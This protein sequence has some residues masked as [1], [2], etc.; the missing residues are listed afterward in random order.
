M[1]GIQTL[2]ADEIF[3]TL[4]NNSFDN[5]GVSLA[6]FEI[7]GGRIQDLLNKRNRLKVLEDGK[8]R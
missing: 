7:Y 1:S 5:V 2:V 8:A 3:A 4:N 6:I